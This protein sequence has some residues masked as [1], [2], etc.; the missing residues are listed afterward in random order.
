ML[1]LA[2]HIVKARMQISLLSLSLTLLVILSCFLATF[3][4]FLKGLLDIVFW[5]LVLP[6][7]EKLL[8]YHLVHRFQIKMTTFLMGSNKNHHNYLKWH[9]FHLLHLVN[10][11]CLIAN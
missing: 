4:M 3:L 1:L 8:F 2:E 9:P 10:L 7:L 11:E 5:N 6:L